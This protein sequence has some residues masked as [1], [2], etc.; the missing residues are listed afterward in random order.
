MGQRSPYNDRY[1]VEQK[2]KTRKSASSAKPKRGV[3]D[4]TPTNTKPAAKKKTGLFGRMRSASRP[5][6]SPAVPISTPRMRQLRRIWWVLWV[7]ALGV[8]LGI[9]Y[10]QNA[11]R[12]GN[13]AYAPWVTVGWVVWIASMAGA[14]YLEFVPIRKERGAIVNAAV[15]ARSEKGPKAGKGEPPAKGGTPTKGEP[16]EPPDTDDDEPPDTGEPT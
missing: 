14:F 8:A 6:S 7:V 4:L 16:P 3:A 9:L 12:G 15:A 13:A 11:V 10:L 5:A 1:K 2:G